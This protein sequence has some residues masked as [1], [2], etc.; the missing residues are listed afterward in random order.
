[1][2]PLKTDRDGC[3]L[4]KQRGGVCGS[5]HGDEEGRGDDRER[6][7]A[8]RDVT[9]TDNMSPPVHVHVLPLGRPQPLHST[10]AAERRARGEGRGQRRRTRPHDHTYASM[11]GMAYFPVLVS[12]APFILGSFTSIIKLLGIPV[13]FLILG[14]DSKF[15]SYL[16]GREREAAVT[17][18]S[19]RPHDVL[20]HCSLSFHPTTAVYMSP[21]SQGQLAQAHGLEPGPPDTVAVCPAL[22][23]ATFPKKSN[24]ANK[25]Q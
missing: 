16:R 15:L 9:L 21:A 11:V 2:S 25:R 4:H 7:D 3:L 8:T 13:L 6:S 14:P 20:P 5:T 22:G 10:Q 17:F 12:M 18:P 1:M 19:C 24:V 23:Q